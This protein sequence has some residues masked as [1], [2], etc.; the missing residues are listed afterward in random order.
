MEIASNVHVIPSGFVN[1]YLI[2]EAGGLTLI[3][4]GLARNERRILAYIAE[5]DRRPGDMLR[6]VITHSDGDHVGCLAALKAAT[7]AR[8][9]ASRLEADAIAAGRASRELKARGLQQ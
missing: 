1:V 6:I 3:D 5:L 7:G 4:T 9:C 2:V 8:A